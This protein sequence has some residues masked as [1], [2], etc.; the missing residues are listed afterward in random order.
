MVLVPSACNPSRFLSPGPT[1]RTIVTKHLFCMDA[2][3]GKYSMVRLQSKGVEHLRPSPLTSKLTSAPSRTG[4]TT[5]ECSIGPESPTSTKSPDVPCLRLPELSP[6][7]PLQS[8]RSLVLVSNKSSG[9]VKPLVRRPLKTMPMTDDWLSHLDDLASK[10][11][12]DPATML[13]FRPGFEATPF[14]MP[15][16]RFL[17][18]LHPPAQFR[19]VLALLPAQLLQRLTTLPLGR[20]PL[21][22]LAGSLSVLLL[23]LPPVLLRLL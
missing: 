5:P 12:T 21:L 3:S 13:E 15:V 7:C 4:S 6:K 2:A 22:L 20:L 19:S 1:P 9:H 8:T 17:C 11:P 16:L 14:S 23:S 10:S 18:Q